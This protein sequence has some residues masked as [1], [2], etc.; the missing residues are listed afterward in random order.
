MMAAGVLT[1]H[2]HPLL[3]LRPGAFH[4]LPDV[5]IVWLSHFS[6]H[7]VDE[8]VKVLQLRVF[9]NGVKHCAGHLQVVDE[10][11]CETLCVQHRSLSYPLTHKWIWMPACCRIVKGDNHFL[12]DLEGIL[13]KLK[14]KGASKEVSL[15]VEDLLVQQH[16]R[17]HNFMTVEADKRRRLLEHVQKLQVCTSQSAVRDTCGCGLEKTDDVRPAVGPEITP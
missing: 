11:N 12:L 5:S 6:V 7:E 3:S 1:L 17:Y 10:G 13:E 4:S 16:Q 14:E 9:I 15:Y 8:I 2:W